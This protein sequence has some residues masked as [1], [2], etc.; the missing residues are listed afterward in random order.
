MKEESGDQFSNQSGA[1]AQLTDSTQ[2]MESSGSE[3]MEPYQKGKFAYLSVILTAFFYVV[4][5]FV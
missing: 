1:S 5:V 4:L 2:A 3:G